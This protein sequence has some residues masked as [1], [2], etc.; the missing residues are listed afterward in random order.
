MSAIL[1]NIPAEAQITRIEYEG[2]RIA[3]YTKNPAYLHKNSYV[4]SEVVNSLKK[5]VVTR[6]EK[7]IRKQESDARQVLERSIPPEA[8]ASNYF[9]DDALGEITVEAENPKLL[10]QE[11]G[12]DLGNA[13]EQ[14]GWK[15]RVRKAPHIK[16]TAI[17]NV[18][19]ALKAGTE[20][21]EKFYRE[22]GEAIFRPRIAAEEHVTI[23][24]LG[25]FQQVGRSCVLVETAES[26]VLLDCGIHPG[27][28]NP[29]DAYPRLDWADISPNEIDA[30]VVSHA[31]LDHQG[32]VPAMYKYGYD[33]PVYCTEPTL[34]LMSMLQNDFVKIAQIE[35][36]R[37]IY[38]QKD[39]RDEIQHTITLPY[40]MVTDIS[41]DIKLVFNNAGHILGSATVHLHVGEGAHNIVY[42]GDYKYGRTALFD[43]ATWNY[44]R[45]ETL[46]T[47]ST[48]GAKEDIMPVREE[49]E[50]KFVNAI[51]E[52][53]TQGGKVLIPIPAVGRA[54]EIL[55][56]LDQYMKNRILVEA[57]VFM[58]G[59][60]SEATAIH[61]SYADYLSRELRTK[62][63]EE[64]VNPF[65]SEYFTEVEHPTD[66]E[67]AYREGPAVIMATSGMLEGGPV[68]DYFEHL[69]PVE[70]NKILFVSYQVQGSM[71]RRVL[72]GGSQASLMGQD[73]KIKIVDVRAKVEKADGFS[74]HSDYNQIIRFVGKVRPKLQLV[75]VNHGEK[76]K[77][78]NLAYA[79]QRI[80][81]VPA[82]HPAVQEA[83]RVY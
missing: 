15:I 53:L 39:I 49:V 5:R 8:G 61:V 68:L 2:P 26:K 44:P 14:T 71:G 6:T 37:L 76:R 38:D 13:M 72:D 67:E 83:I 41:P 66:R 74:G 59:M 46:I 73:G 50:M 22:L 11:A 30:I 19:Y 29:W 17:Q 55:I 65:K 81:R 80:Y 7:S 57:P 60:I 51:N 42:T 16:S 34:P 12:F 4:I 82:I 77:T 21:R 52:T 54:Q 79:I 31:H 27:S 69:A 3:L 35:G 28:R 1:N 48:Y 9:F 45:V 23:K 18:Y 25:A 47:E 58:E 62:I 64:G 20:V 63:L 24:T 10:S 56:V 70:K 36:G 78:E 33:G 32:F 40:G 43:S 75:L